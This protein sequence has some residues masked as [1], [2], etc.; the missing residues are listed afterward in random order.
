MR[1]AFHMENIEKYRKADYEI[2]PIYIKRWSPRAFSDRQV[3]EDVL[4]SLFEAARWAPSAA[5]IQPWRFVFARSENDRKKF[6]SFINEGNVIWCNKAPVLV[7]VISKEKRDSGQI[8]PTH[9]FDTG[10][11]WGYLTLEAIRK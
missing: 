2:D 6:L 3:T 5:N 7:A 11:A 9:A 10:T 1:E 8:N 4:F